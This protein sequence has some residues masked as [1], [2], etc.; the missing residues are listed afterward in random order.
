MYEK[1]IPA[2]DGGAP[3]T[4]PA[5]PNWSKFMH[6]IMHDIEAE[7]NQRM[8][9]VVYPESESA[10]REWIVNNYSMYEIEYVWLTALETMTPLD[11][12]PIDTPTYLS[13]LNSCG[14]LLLYSKQNLANQDAI[15]GEWLAN[16]MLRQC[17]HS[18][19]IIK[20]RITH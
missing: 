14:L 15:N 1:Y 6:I 9:G 3:W 16:N 19:P 10:E 11:K 20:G 18:I 4:L 5:E 13:T 12:L 17:V 8:L 7:I 2:L